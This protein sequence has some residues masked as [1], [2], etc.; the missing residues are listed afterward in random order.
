MK[1]RSPPE[2]QIALRT[3]KSQADAPCPL[4]MGAFAPPLVDIWRNIPDKNATIYRATSLLGGSLD[5]GR[6]AQDG[7]TLRGGR[8]LTTDNYE[9]TWDLFKI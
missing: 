5:G 2:R 4:Q 3:A 9:C 8:M 1:P 7:Y 6:N